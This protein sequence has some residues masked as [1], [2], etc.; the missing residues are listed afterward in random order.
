M[1]AAM[2]WW[3]GRVGSCLVGTQYQF[4]KTKRV[5]EMVGGDVCTT[6]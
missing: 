2:I 3:E 5:L 4:C 6:M 1:V